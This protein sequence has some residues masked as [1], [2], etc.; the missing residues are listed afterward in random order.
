VVVC[1]HVLEHVEDERAAL[2][3]ML[4][5]ARKRVVLVLPRT[6]V[7]LDQLLAVHEHHYT[8]FYTRRGLE[9]LLCPLRGWYRVWYRKHYA[10]TG[11][12]ESWLVC[13]DKG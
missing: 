1:M 12:H 10:P 9:R 8:P 6:I 4:R 2:W 3:E 7:R 11:E 13:I 5:V